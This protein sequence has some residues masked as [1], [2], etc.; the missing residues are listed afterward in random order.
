MK[1]D[2]CTC[3][4]CGTCFCGDYCPNCGQKASTARISVKSSLRSLIATIT[5]LDGKFFRTM[6]NLFWRPGHLVRDYISG[7][8]AMYVHPVKL[9]STLVAIYLF[10]IFIFGIDPGSVHILGD[11]NIS[12]N[13]HSDSLMAFFGLLSTMLSNKV[14]SSMLSAFICLPSFALMFLR[15]KISIPQNSISTDSASIKLNLAEH[16]C[17]LIYAACLDFTLSVVLRLAE[18]V[19]MSHPAI[20]TA[21]DLLFL[22]IPVVVYKQLYKM[23]WW[24][25]LWRGFVAIMLTLTILAVLVILIFGITYGIDAVK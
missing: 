24:P 10:V 5:S 19:G 3:L 21:S 8:R 2:N 20:Q 15:K 22:L 25:A 12:E 11:E 1:E 17:A 4:N 18:A 9:L 6:G 7:K 16:F 13:A 23:N 14:V